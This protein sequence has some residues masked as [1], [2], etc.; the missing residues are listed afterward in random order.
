MRFGR[1]LPPLV[2]FVVVSDSRRDFYIGYLGGMV[3]IDALKV[4]VGHTGHKVFA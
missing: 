1:C 3:D 2:Q 4:I